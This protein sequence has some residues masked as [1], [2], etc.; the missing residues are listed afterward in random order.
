MYK[1]ILSASVS[2]SNRKATRQL[3]PAPGMN[4]LS[5]ENAEQVFWSLAAM[6]DIPSRLVLSPIH[7][8][9]R[10]SDGTVYGI[11]VRDGHA[12]FVDYIK[13]DPNGSRDRIRLERLFHKRWFLCRSDVP[14]LFN[15]TDPDRIRSCGEADLLLN[16]F[17]V[18][19]RN[20]PDDP[21]G[22][23]LF[24]CNFLERL[25]E[26]MDLRPIF[27]ALTATGRQVFIALPHYSMNI[28]EEIC[29]DATIHIL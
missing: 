12:I 17:N 25:D 9:L 21:N 15:G 24:L 2:F 5:G 22:P 7:G 20:I 3:S 23:P 6:F 10:W 28:L 4:L 16:K 11:S 18:F 27:E 13:P 26:A 29:H 1:R 8:E 19:I 14:Y